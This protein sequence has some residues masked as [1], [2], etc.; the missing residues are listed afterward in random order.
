MTFEEKVQ[1]LNKLFS[2][3]PTVRKEAM[4][5]DVPQPVFESDEELSKALDIILEYG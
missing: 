5:Q 2:N 1:W 4:E 3:S